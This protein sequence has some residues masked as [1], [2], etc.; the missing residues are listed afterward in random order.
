MGAYNYGLGNKDM[1]RAGHNALLRENSGRSF[2]GL[3]T[4]SRRWQQFCEWA[5]G[6]GIKRMEKIVKDDVIRYGTE[7]AD[8]VKAGEMEESTAQNYVSAVNTVMAIARG[9]RAVSV[10]PT[11][12]CGIGRRTG[13]ATVNRAVG[14]AEHGELKERLPERLGAL[15]DL[16]RHLGLRFKESALLDARRALKQASKERRVEVVDGT[17]GDRKDSCVNE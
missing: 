16:Q 17:K 7:L 1:A 3:D 15:L 4:V 13:I 6:K 2:S 8:K 12:D 9:D 10:S 5:N 11:A 14:E